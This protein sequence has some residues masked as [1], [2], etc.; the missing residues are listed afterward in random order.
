LGPAPGGVYNL[1]CVAQRWPDIDEADE[2]GPANEAALSLL[3]RELLLDRTAK[4][5]G[6]TL[7][8]FIDGW[9]SVLDL[10]ARVDML[11]PAAPLELREALTELVRRIRQLQQDALSDDDLP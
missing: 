3:I 11:L 6:P 2:T 10:L 7:A 8:A 1:D 4:L 9:T 5:D